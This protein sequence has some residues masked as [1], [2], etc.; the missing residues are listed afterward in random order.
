AERRG[1]GA[2]ARLASS[3]QVSVDGDLGYF[4]YSMRSP[5]SPSGHTHTV[6]SRFHCAICP[7][8]GRGKF[9]L[10]SFLP[11]FRETL[12]PWGMSGSVMSPSACV[13]IWRAGRLATSA[14]ERGGGGAAPLGGVGLSLTRPVLLHCPRPD[15]PCRVVRPPAAS[16]RLPPSRRART[17]WA[18]A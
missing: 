13:G 1:E 9:S 3:E 18:R 5:P 6:V 12:S 16:L 11:L 2:R 8:L 10:G 14:S 15:R 17:P 4:L 7:A